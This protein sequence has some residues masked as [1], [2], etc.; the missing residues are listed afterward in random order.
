MTQPTPVPSPSSASVSRTI[1]GEIV[2]MDARSG[3]VLVRETVASAT[4]KGQK[5]FRRAVTL[6][7]GS[8]TKL[9]RGKAPVH[10]S[11][12][13]VGDYVVARYAET[14]T[15]M[16]AFSIRAAEVVV[17][18]TPAAAPPPSETADPRGGDSRPH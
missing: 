18:T 6:V 2:S 14:P 12:L 13:K 9:S 16:T 4:Q 3:S 11:D 1:A 17:R 7:I 10:V 8:G 5:P 15:G